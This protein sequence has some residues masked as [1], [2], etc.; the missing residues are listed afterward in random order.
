MWD[1]LYK[2]N[3]LKIFLAYKPNESNPIN[4]ALLLPFGN[5]VHYKYAASLDGV[6]EYQGGPL[7]LW[8]AIEWACKNEFVTFDLGRTRKGT[9]V[10]GFKRSLNG[11][12]LY[13]DDLYYY[14][15]DFVSPPTPDQER[16]EYIM[17]LWSRLPLSATKILGPHIRRGLR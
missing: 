13:L 7:V 8:K 5:K 17:E 1:K 16:F 14:P 10:Y 9:G 12:E 2:K 6:R 11:Q 3:R 15:K 4:A